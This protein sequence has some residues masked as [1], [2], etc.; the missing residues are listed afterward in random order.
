MDGAEDKAMEED[1]DLE[2][3][4]F[5]SQ[6]TEE[7][8]ECLQFWLKTID[9]LDQ[10]EDDDR[11]LR[12]SPGSLQD[13]NRKLRSLS[14]SIKV[15]EK[16][17]HGHHMPSKMK[18]VKSYSEDSPGFSIT[19]S[20]NT[21][22]RSTSSHPSHLRKFDTIMR[23]G[24]NVQELRARF[25]LQPDNS[26]L[27]DSSK[28]TSL[29][30][31][32]LTQAARSHVS[33]RLEALQKLGLLKV[34]QNNRSPARNSAEHQHGSDQLTPAKDSEEHRPGSDQLPPAKDSEEHRPGSDQLPPAKDSEEHRPDSGQLP[35]AKDFEEHRPGSDQL[36]P[37]KDSKEH[38]PGSDQLPPAKD[39]KEHRPGSDQLPPAKDSEGHRPGSDQLP[40]AKDSEEHRPGSDQL[41]P[42][43]DS[44]GQRPGSDQLPPAKDSEEHRPGSDQLPP[45][46]DSKEHRPGSDQLP[47]AKDSEEQRIDSNQLPPAK[48]SELNQNHP[49][50]AEDFLRSVQRKPGGDKIW[51]P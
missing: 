46:K 33:P 35:P 32:H 8:K 29:S 40:P 1:P 3:D 43:K 20:P 25:N 14:E 49:E 12:N 48:D 2:G 9:S 13:Q 23:S 34:K 36:P 19:V 44:E 38:R 10:E 4:D 42:A 6:L 45:V 17:D 50:P 27:E 31:R 39:S 21:G 47:P 41:P 15:S 37:A 24:V 11:N 26:S 16:S 18:I 22:Q 51:P 7:E 28:E 5:L 30:S